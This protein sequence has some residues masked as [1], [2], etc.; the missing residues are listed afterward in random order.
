MTEKSK[1]QTKILIVIII[2]IMTAISL[3]YISPMGN[4]KSNATD[5]DY[6]YKTF[7]I[8][9]ENKYS[10]FK[11]TNENTFFIHP[12]I[13]SEVKGL[14]SIKTDS[15]YTFEFSIAE[16]SKKGNILYTIEKNGLT[17]DSFQIKSGEKKSINTNLKIGD[18]IYITADKNG[19]TN[20]DWGHVAITKTDSLFQTTKFIII[21]AW[22][23]VLIVI[24]LQGNIATSLACHILLC[25]T[26]AAE[27]YNYGFLSGQSIINYMLFIFFLFASNLFN[28]KQIFKNNTNTCT[29]N[30]VH[31]LSMLT[32]LLQKF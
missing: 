16:K 24:F 32:R 20:Y 18:D 26:L 13:S 27:N 19:E 29:I 17:L 1:P 22:A 25:S 14:L 12:G 5:N 31:T 3:G 4:G 11:K 15:D 2:V 10:T 6:R 21:S 30:L 23:A 28:Q 7:H 8:E 9:K